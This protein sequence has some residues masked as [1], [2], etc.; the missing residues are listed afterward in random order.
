M[1]ADRINPRRLNP[2]S[3]GAAVA[4]NGGVLAAL[5]LAAPEILQG[6][7]PVDPPIDTYNVPPDPPP[8]EVTKKKVERVERL[9][10]VVP[11]QPVVLPSKDPAFTDTTDRFPSTDAHPDPGPAAEPTR[12]PIPPVLVDAKLDQRFADRFQPTYPSSELRASREGAVTVKVL[13]G[14]DG[15]V[16]AVEPVRADSAAFLDATRRQALGNWRFTPATRDGIP[17]ESWRTMTVRFQLS[18]S[19]RRHHETWAGR[20]APGILSKQH[21]FPQISVADACDPRFSCVPV[22]SREA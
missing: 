14:M 8:P 11:K 9:P 19:W 16:K 2:A 18:S 7:R 22:A 12:E 20:S 6:P 4:I 1:Y 3:L 13:I 21:D 17:V 10:I 5:F 15:R